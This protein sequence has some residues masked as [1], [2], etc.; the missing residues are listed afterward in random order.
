MEPKA[1][2]PKWR[3]KG[4]ILEPRQAEGQE[5]PKGPWARLANVARGRAATG[6]FGGS[7]LTC[8]A[9]GAEKKPPE[10]CATPCWTL[11]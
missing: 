1:P 4:I 11:A 3:H 10:A 2:L 6:M 9:L 7:G 8:R 5:E